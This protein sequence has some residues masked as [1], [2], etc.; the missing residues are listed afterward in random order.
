[1]PWKINSE[2]EQR[3]GFVQIAMRATTGLAELCR[4]SGI[5]RK[6][7]YKWIARFKDR[8]R[9]GLWDESRSAHQVH[10]RPAQKW[11]DR[12]RRCRAEHC[13]WG[14]P[15]IHWSLQHRFG[16]ID[17]PSEAAISRWL[18]NWRLTRR[19]RAHVPRGPAILRTTLSAARLPNDVW[20]VDFK[21]WFRTSDGTKVE[22]LTIRDLASRYILG[23][24]LL[25]RQSVEGVRLVMEGLF[26]QY[27]I[28]LVIRVDNGSP[29]GA[30]GAL[31][32]TRLS[33]WWI[34]LGIKVEFIE[35]GHPEQNGAHEQMHRVYKAETLQPVARTLRGQKNRTRQWCWE[36]NHKRPHEALGMR[37]PADDY[38]KSRRK[39][40]L[41]LRPWKYP[42]EWHSRLVKGKG[43]I[44][45]NGRM[46][47]VGEAFEKERLGLKRILPGKWMVYFG[48][49]LVGELHD[50]DAG[51]I[52]A[53]IYRK[54]RRR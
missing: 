54:K 33:A 32:L 51:G 25:A 10:N 24:Y 36:Y 15:K 22:P 14:A 47:F 40:P 35:P 23:F 4:R 29:F 26:Q 11:L 45:L 21:G 5:S 13:T 44:S 2:R 30:S 48:P 3:W 7:A 42:K 41:R 8:G 46:R 6:T 50:T 12:L 37:V 34:K 28:P 20:T 39:L 38:R 43:M 1:M 17:L 53:V 52:R 16:V 27:G 9:R 19:R 18:K 49:C 31:G